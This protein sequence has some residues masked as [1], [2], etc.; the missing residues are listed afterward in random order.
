MTR[1]PRHPAQHGAG[2]G[3]EA[4][5]LRGRRAER[6]PAG[7]KPLALVERTI[8]VTTDPG[9]AVW[10]PFGGLCPAAVCALKL[11]RECR[12]AEIVREF[13]DAAVERLRDAARASASRGVRPCA[14]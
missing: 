5:A 4:L 10:E 7:E 2:R 11:E 1:A 6:A 9:D 13:Y 8:R 12:G 14:S 3:E